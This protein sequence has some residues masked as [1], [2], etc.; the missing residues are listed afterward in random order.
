M[1]LLPAGFGRGNPTKSLVAPVQKQPHA[2]IHV[3]V[4][5]ASAELEGKSLSHKRFTSCVG[6][7]V[8]CVQVKALPF[9]TSKRLSPGPHASLFERPSSNSRRAMSIHASSS[10]PRCLLAVS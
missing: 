7:R 5:V 4:H 2:F 3:L 9:R 6:S 8:C 1:A 10:F